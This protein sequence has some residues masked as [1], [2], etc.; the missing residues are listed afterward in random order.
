[1][2]L[3]EI[4]AAIAGNTKRADKD[5]EARTGVKLAID[6]VF[7]KH[8]FTAYRKE[9]DVSI[10]AGSGSVDFA[11]DHQSLRKARFLVSA[12]STQA[13]TITVKTKEWIIQRFPNIPSIIAGYP[14]YGYIEGKRLYVVPYTLS[15]GIIRLD[16]DAKPTLVNNDDSNEIT[17]LDE[18][19]IAFGTMWVFQAVQMFGEA[20][21]WKQIFSEALDTAIKGDMGDYAEE[22]QAESGR[23]MPNPIV[24]AYLDP[25]QGHRKSWYTDDG[26]R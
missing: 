18:T 19:I 13:W 5:A 20:A 8:V 1:M 23:D 9:V 21:Q 26:G 12:A 4:L 16:Y 2:T 11:A 25:F 10:S 7:A 22:M 3:V 17:G 15:D 14:S 24:D 6:R